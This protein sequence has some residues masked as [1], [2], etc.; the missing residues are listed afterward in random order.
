MNNS[1]KKDKVDFNFRYRPLVDSPDAILIRYLNSFKPTERKY[2]IL[3]ALRAFYLVA[4]YG[5]EGDFANPKDLEAFVRSLRETYK[6]D[7]SDSHSLSVEIELRIRQR[8]S[9]GWFSLPLF[10]EID[11]NTRENTQKIFPCFH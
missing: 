6:D 8:D 11:A 1:A 2:M 7:Y 9:C 10:P 3:K 4:A 5:Q